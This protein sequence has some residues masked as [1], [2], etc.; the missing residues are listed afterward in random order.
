M[1][2][3]L[4]FS[5]L[6]VVFF[7]ISC[8][9]K[10][11]YQVVQKTDTNGYKYEIVTN[12]PMGV[13]IY[14]LANGLKV[15]LSVNKDEP[16]IKTFIPVKAGSSYDP[17]ET[18]GLAHYLEHMMFKGSDEI[19]T[20]NWEKEKPLIQEISNLYEQHKAAKGK[21]AKAKIYAK[22]DSVST[23]AAKYAVA[24]EYD[25]LVAVVGAKGTNAYTSQERTVYMNDIPSNELEKWLEI[26]KERFSGVVLRIFHTEL[27]TVYEEFNM[28]QDEDADRVNNTIMSNLFKKH[29]YGTQTTLGKA[30]H[31]KN[32]SMVNIMDYFH[33]YYVPNNMAIALSGDLDFEKTIQL[34]DKTFGT[35][36]AKP[37][38]E[39]KAPVEDPITAPIVKEVLGPD[40]ES[41]EMAFRFDGIGSRDQKIVTIIDGILNNSKAGLIDL[42]LNQKQKVLR[43]GCY[44]D[45]MIDYGYHGFFGMPREGQKMEEVKDLI[46]AQIEKIKK[47]EFDDWLIEAI[48]NN[49]RL[50]QIRRQESNWRAHEFAATFANNVSWADNLKEIDE[51]EKITKEEVIQFVKE[52]YKNN[53]VLVYKR[54]GEDKNIVKVEKPK[55][56]PAAI[57]RKSKSKFYEKLTAQKTPALKPLW[58]DYKKDIQCKDLKAGMEFD[59]LKNNSNELFKLFYIYDMGKNHNKK[60]PLAV[61]YLP[62]LGTDKYSAEDLQKEMFKYGLSLGVNTNEDRC[63]VYITGLKKSLDKGIELIEHILSNLKADQDAYDKYVDGIL[64][65]RADRKLNKDEILWGALM[66]YGKYGENSSYTNIIPADELKKIDPQSLTSLLGGLKEYKHRVFYYGSHEKSEIENKL[67]QQHKVADQLKD[68]PAPVVYPEANIT[69]NEVYFVDYD[70]VQANIIMLGKDEELNV[71]LMPEI[72]LF[73]EYYGGSMASIVFQ[74]I[75][76]SRALAYTAFSTFTTPSKPKESHYS[77]SYVATSAD[78][79]NDATT[80]LLDLLNKMP[81]EQKQFDEAKGNMLKKIESE[82]ITKDRVFWN[83]LNNK[84][85]GIDYDVR[86]TIY[87]KVKKDDLNI[88]DKFFTQHVAN[89]KHRFLVIGNKKDINMKV[90]KKLGK[91]HMLSLEQIFNY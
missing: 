40:A 28:Y 2:G 59:Y 3:K 21:E 9:P 64:K 70:M 14:T 8:A 90:L 60:L 30:E 13:R 81:K 67:M 77:L 82:R 37:V 65:K 11:K 33:T 16:R 31:L 54:K 74:E 32:P 20:T 89:K 35:L 55:I 52:H 1:R 42:N 45:F 80:A 87:D 50:N 53:Y 19:G 72:K 29:P 76:E 22:I 27:E 91:V 73:N 58:L 10:E 36:K 78:K 23:L 6:A 4:M 69:E 7:I 68:I 61:N 43:A 83:Y 56:T 84:D 39:F 75:R 15:Y 25:K 26:E 62:Y 46:L 63:Y 12:D 41:L 88:L 85:R 5:L 38:P 47:G 17:A 71:D 48:I 57:D 86:K 51:L 24:N 34:I 49:H 79:V 18:T 66:N 44:T